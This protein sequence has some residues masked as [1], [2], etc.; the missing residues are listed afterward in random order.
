MQLRTIYWMLF[1][2]NE[3]ELKNILIDCKPD[4]FVKLN[5]LLNSEL[6]KFYD[7]KRELEN[8]PLLKKRLSQ[9]KY[10]TDNEPIK[11][12]VTFYTFMEKLDLLSFDE[13]VRAIDQNVSYKSNPLGNDIYKELQAI[14][15][16]ILSSL[17][18]RSNMLIRLKYGLQHPDYY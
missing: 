13:L 8:L 9:L 3:D 2:E 11:C 10:I 18:D 4:D 15:D 16:D 14:I 7:E 17:T 6:D 1:K 5:N 12:D